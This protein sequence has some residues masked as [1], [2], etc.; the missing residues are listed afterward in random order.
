[1][2]LFKMQIK[3]QNV[4]RKFWSYEDHLFTMNLFMMS[5]QIPWHSIRSDSELTKVQIWCK[6][7]GSGV[8]LSDM[9]FSSNL[10]YID[11]PCRLCCL[12]N[13]QWQKVASGWK[14][15]N[16]L[17]EGCN[18]TNKWMWGSYI[19]QV[20]SCV[21]MVRVSQLAVNIKLAAVRRQ[22]GESHRC[23]LSWLVT[24]SRGLIF[25]LGQV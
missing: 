1:M 12:K 5:K 3:L 22:I 4:F 2:F 8:I 25:L 23:Y 7:W 13:P 17:D 15:I 6:L 14:G 21:H 10:T 11:V 24:T 19:S 20:A 18:I 9:F 16:P